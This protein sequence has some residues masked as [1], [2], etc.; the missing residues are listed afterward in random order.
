[1]LDLTRVIAGPTCTRFLAAQGARVLR[2]DPPGYPEIVDLLP[3]TTA[4]KTCAAVDLR[5]SAGEARIAALVAE[6]DVLVCGLRLAALGRIGV[7]EDRLAS[8]NPAL[9]VARVGAYGWRGPWLDRRGFDSLVQ[10][11]TGIAA[12]GQTN[13]GHI[14]TS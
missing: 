3:T 12:E 2:I 1:M 13:C 7:D 5:S 4:G 8:L 6:S 9:V 14:G 10:M 11:S